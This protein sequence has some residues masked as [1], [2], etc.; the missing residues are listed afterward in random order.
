[1]CFL[2]TWNLNRCTYIDFRLRWFPHPHYQQLISPRNQFTCYRWTVSEPLFHPTH[3]INV[4]RVQHQRH[5][6]T[7]R[8]PAEI[9]R[10]SCN[11]FYTFACYHGC[12]SPCVQVRLEGYI[13]HAG[14]FT[15]F[16]NGW[17][18]RVMCVKDFKSWVSYVSEAVGIEEI[19]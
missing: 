11:T 7:N 16:P 5:V 1:M 10:E 9:S 12:Q 14:N 18:E 13:L 8:S 2:F 19:F 4:N 3:H 17:N 15:H 6:T